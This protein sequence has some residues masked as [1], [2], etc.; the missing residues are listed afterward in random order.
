MFID[1]PGKL[2]VATMLTDY[3]FLGSYGWPPPDMHALQASSP[4]CDISEECVNECVDRC[5]QYWPTTKY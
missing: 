2:V 5:Y 3:L 4:Y 1:S